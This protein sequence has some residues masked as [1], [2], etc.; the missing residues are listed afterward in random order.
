MTLRAINSK[1][2]LNYQIFFILLVFGFFLGL[3]SGP[4]IPDELQT[5]NCARNINLPLGLGTSINCDSGTQLRAAMDPS[6]LFEKD[7]IVKGRV[8]T[9]T[10]IE[11]T[12]PGNAFVVWIL[13][14]PIEYVWKNF[15]ATNFENFNYL[16]NSLNKAYELEN[17]DQNIN[18]SFPSVSKM[19]PVYITFIFYHFLTLLLSFYLFG[20]IL[21]INVFNK[22][23]YRNPAIWLGALIF[24]NDITKQFFFSPNSQM[25]HILAPI[26][27][28][29]FLKI[30]KEND[31][32]YKKLFYFSLLS[33]IGMLFYFIFV[34]PLLIISLCF[35]FKNKKKFLYKIPQL[36]PVGF[37][38]ITPFIF[39][40]ILVKSF[41]PEVD[42][43]F[44]DVSQNN[45]GFVIL[46]KFKEGGVISL[47][48][49]FFYFYS[50]LWYKILRH[51][52]IVPLLFIVGLL[53]FYKKSINY[54]IFIEPFAFSIIL[55]V[56]INLYSLMEC[57]LLTAV[58]ISFLP[59]I[60]Y[61]C[62]K[63]IKIENLRKTQVTFIS[64][65]FLY[66]TFS[67]VKTSPLGFSNEFSE[68]TIAK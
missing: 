48:N 49:S 9:P 53:Y 60:G 16:E 19:I 67:I 42:I 27:T 45:P 20:K 12:T 68:Y 24:I 11:F 47:L 5:K 31:Y 25:F 44:H 15:I 63:H 6:L 8:L 56:L 21:N 13:S 29:Y 58:S 61:L 40:L 3:F 33:G 54:R 41:V 22:T 17:I 28:I 35:L 57:R 51:S 59:G 2:N 23:E 4:K 1:I 64:I 55:T 65:L 43:Y 26:L 18:D 14:R 66:A 34:V 37:L 50:C 38:F 39:Y 46:K 36:I 10:S 7:R 62:K 32:S 52:F 30:L